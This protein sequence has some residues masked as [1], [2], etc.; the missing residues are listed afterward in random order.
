MR[1]FNQMADW[2]T[3]R[4]P[5][6]RINPVLCLPGPPSMRARACSVTTAV[7]GF[8]RW[9]EQGKRHPLDRSQWM[10]SF[11][12]GWPHPAVGIALPAW[13]RPVGASGAARIDPAGSDFH[14]RCG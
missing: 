13:E 14:C 12:P 5:G 3:F 2:Q 6:R 4:W 10:M 7:P 11:R 9:L 8:I 1:Y